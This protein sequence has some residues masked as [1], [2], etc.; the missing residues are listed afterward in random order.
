MRW[1]GH[2]ARKGGKRNA[3][4]ILVWKLKR[5]R[6]LERPRRRCVDNIEMKVREIVWGGMDWIDFGLS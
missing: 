3:Y 1:V 4:R 6:L 5:K 2:A